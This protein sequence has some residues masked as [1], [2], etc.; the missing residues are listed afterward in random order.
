MVLRY[1][2]LTTNIVPQ[3][4]LEEGSNSGIALSLA[5]YRPAPVP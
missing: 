5:A 1:G 4:R 3:L 2:G